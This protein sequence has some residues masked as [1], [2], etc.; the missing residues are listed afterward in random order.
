MKQRILIIDDDIEFINQIRASF[1]L[2]QIVGSLN[3]EQACNYLSENAFDLILLDLKLDP[4]SEELTG[5]KQFGVIQEIAQGIPIVV[6]TADNKTDTIVTAMKLGASDFLRKSEFDY[7]GWQNKINLLIQ[8][9]LLNNRL[10]KIESDSFAFIGVSSVI[11]EIK[12]TLS[13]LSKE[14]QITVLLTGETGT[15]KEVAARYLH[16]IGERK[17]NPFIAVQLSSIQ[18]N[19]LESALFG[20]KKGSYTG[21]SY[22][23]LGFFRS[24]DKGVLFLD[25]IGD[26]PPELQI[27]L[28]RFLETKTI[29]IVGQDDDIKLDVQIVTATNQNLSSLVERG[30]FRAD[31]YYRLKNFQVE[32]PPLRFRK[33]DVNPLIDYYIKKTGYSDGIGLLIVDTLRILNDYNWPGNVR[34]LRNAVDAMLLKLKL[35]KSIK[36]D[37]SCIP[38][39]ILVES[40]HSPQQYENLQGKNHDLNRQIAELELARIESILLKNVGNKGKTANDLELTTDR[41]RYKINKYANLLSDVISQYPTI[42]KCY[43]KDIL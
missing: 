28:L 18:S 34:E 41:L 20:H 33:E 5:L 21:A 27:K 25:E 31:L 15:G 16:S 2:Y 19:L 11:D 40:K 8:N 43:L 9:R 35:H 13:I 29:N 10:S 6:V 39:D 32:L 3:I 37:N 7:F 17:N 23:R 12:K 30:S 4:T 24:A 42:K 36:I 22:D 26:I 1:S 14:P 38:S